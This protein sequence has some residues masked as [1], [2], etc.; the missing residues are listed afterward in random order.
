MLQTPRDV[1][2]F[3]YRGI[4]ALLYRW[5]R[6]KGEDRWKRTLRNLEKFSRHPFPPGVHF[7]SQ[8]VT[9]CDQCMNRNKWQLICVTEAHRE[10]A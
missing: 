2:D 7:S 10:D 8:K 6:R 5:S 4:L 3:A 1:P 9:L